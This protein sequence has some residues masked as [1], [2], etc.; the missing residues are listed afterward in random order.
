MTKPRILIVVGTPLPDTLVHA[1]AASYESGVRAGGGEIRL[2]DLA[3]DPI[4][5]H[6]RSR[7]QLRAPRGPED[8]PLDE[9]VA[10]YVEDIHWADHIVLVYPQWWGTYP[11]ALKAFID[12]VILSGSAFR[13][14]SVGKGWEKLLTGRTARLIMT[15]DSPR[16]WN[17]FIYRNASETSLT[18][19]ILG[20]C[21]I[22]TVGVTRFSEVRHREAEIRSRWVDQTRALGEQDAASVLRRQRWA[23]DLTVAAQK[24]D[25][26]L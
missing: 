1:L 19:A 4:P 12:R 9:E 17:R 25:E 7:E 8:R 14:A 6:P 20:Y 22:K 10:G 26:N 11:A 21:G 24:G 16:W 2:I 3:R 23:D 5:A 13:Y 15:M 18:R